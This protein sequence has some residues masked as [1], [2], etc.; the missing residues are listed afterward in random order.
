MLEKKLVG[1]ARRVIAEVRFP[2]A[3]ARSH[4]VRRSTITPLG[5]TLCFDSQS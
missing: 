4:L 2:I 3:I 5:I 1:R